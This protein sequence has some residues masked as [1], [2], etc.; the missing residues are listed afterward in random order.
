MVFDIDGVLADAQGRQHLIEGSQ[1]DWKGF[2]ARCGEDAPIL[3]S[4][5]LLDVVDAD[6]A[7]VL[8][9]GRPLGVQDATIQ[10]L[11]RHGL[12]W[13]V[14]VMRDRGDYSNSLVFKQQSARFLKARGFELVLA[15]EDDRRNC[16]MFE[17][18]GVPALYIHSGYY[19]ERDDKASSA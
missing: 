3:S 2:F 1:R 17:E 9:T 15:V 7:V 19:D 10:W 11:D 6:V 16:E 18:E 13:D 8:L 5:R 4:V 12:R 14:L